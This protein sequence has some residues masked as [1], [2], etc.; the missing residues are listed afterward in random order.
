[1]NRDTLVFSLDNELWR[2]EGKK[3]KGMIVKNESGIFLGIDKAAGLNTVNCPFDASEK[4]GVKFF[5]C[6]EKS[7]AH[8]LAI[9]FFRIQ[10][11]ELLAGIKNEPKTSTRKVLENSLNEVRKQMASFGL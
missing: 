2:L 9:E 10:E 3:L 1:M 11:R 4:D 8:E 6:F 5:K 7:R